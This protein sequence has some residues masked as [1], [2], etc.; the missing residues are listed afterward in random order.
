METASQTLG[1]IGEELAFHFLSARGYKVLLKN[2]ACEL[3]EIDLI[4]KEK[5]V[6]VFIE[7]KT[8]SSDAMGMPAEAVTPL[9]RRQ[10]VKTAHYY[11]KRYGIHDWPC[12]FDVV[13]VLLVETENP[14][15]DVIQD[16]FGEGE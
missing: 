15:I 4:A 7:V 13:S 14:Q 1:L 9:K 8:R 2:Y 5:G 11:L 6:L 10:I 3:G 16:A 12:R